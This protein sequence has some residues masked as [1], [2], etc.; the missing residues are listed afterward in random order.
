MAT[1]TDVL[2]KLGLSHLC[3]VLVD[4]TLDSLHER[5][6]ASRPAFL[7]LLKQRGVAC[8]PE[9]Q[10][11]TNGLLRLKREG[12]IPP[13]QASSS[14]TTG[15]APGAATK[16][17]GTASD[18]SVSPLIDP[19]LEM[20]DGVSWRFRHLGE[21]P[22]VLTDRMAAA[23]VSALSQL[24][25]CEDEWAVSSDSAPRARV[26]DAAKH[27]LQAARIVLEAVPDKTSEP[28]KIFEAGRLSM[29]AHEALYRVWRDLPLAVNRHFLIERA[30]DDASLLT[31]L[32]ESPRSRSGLETGM[33]HMRNETDSRGGYSV[34][35][36]EHARPSELMMVMTLH[37]GS[38][39]GRGNLMQWLKA[40]RAHDD[41]ILV[42][43]TSQ[44]V[45]TWSLL[46]PRQMADDYPRLVQIV[47]EVCERW[48]VSAARRLL[49]GIS[50]GGTFAWLCGLREGSIFTH[51]A[52]LIPGPMFGF[53]TL[54]ALL[55][56]GDAQAAH[57]PIGSPTEPHTRPPTQAPTSCDDGAPGYEPAAVKRVASAA[58]ITTTLCGK[59]V[60]MVVGTHDSLFNVAVQR[61]VAAALEAAGAQLTFVEKTDMGHTHPRE[62]MEPI[63]AW[64]K[65]HHPPLPPPAG[66]PQAVGVE[67]MFRALAAAK[68]TT[69]AQQL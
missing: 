31:R 12:W 28:S 34:F 16:L 15:D 9:R 39:H 54:A 44:H 42:A 24:P 30:R 7:D 3:P 53:P 8:L 14:A 60:Y 62:E 32:S 45:Q 50:D 66:A 69:D 55:Q 47:D 29:L 20:L 5:L 10:H 38:G 56:M 67:T 48:P 21:M 65:R 6:A 58:G 63:L 13:C 17:V 57:R 22:T 2:A 41:L 51:L 11:L 43:P 37:G 1:L 68:S 35:V 49:T 23:V 25:R 18:A 64:F 59:P 36:P 27:A 4:D 61:K 40:V 52:P 19:V 26:L 33:F 46:P